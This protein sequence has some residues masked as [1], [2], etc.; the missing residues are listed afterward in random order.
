[1]SK[2]LF[3]RAAVA[4]GAIGIGSVG[5]GLGREQVRTE[6]IEPVVLTG[7]DVGFRMVGRQGDR[8]AGEWV[9]R[10]DG[11]WV[12]TASAWDIGRGSE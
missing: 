11:K 5:Y 3:V 1:M 2:P 4:I 10:V 9:V 12:A 6:R 7:A 8:P